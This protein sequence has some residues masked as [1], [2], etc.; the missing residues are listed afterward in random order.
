MSDFRRVK[1][2]M[3]SYGLRCSMEYTFEDLKRDLGIGHEVQFRYIG[4]EYSISHS[5]N[6]WHL[7]E[8]YK[9]EQT[10]NTQWELL[11]Y[12]TINGTH[13]SEIWHGVEVTVI[14]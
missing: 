7:C 6:G 10:F 2:F 4:K 13:L 11:N 5:Q 12:G 1:T 14:L 3:Q 9:D 8:F